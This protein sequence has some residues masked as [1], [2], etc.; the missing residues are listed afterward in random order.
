MSG[1]T[2]ISCV[3]PELDKGPIANAKS[4]ASVSFLFNHNLN[5]NSVN[6]ND[7]TAGNNKA[8]VRTTKNDDYYQRRRQRRKKK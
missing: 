3:H 4:Y 6:W 1:G 5:A 8:V 7:V 2:K